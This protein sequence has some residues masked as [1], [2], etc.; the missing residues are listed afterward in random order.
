MQFIEKRLEVLQETHLVFVD[1]K[2]A[3]DSIP[4]NK[5]WET[6]ENT[7]LS[8]QIIQAVKKFICWISFKDGNKK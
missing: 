6:L 1:L 4:I 5:L 3:C 8:T 2:R 7:G